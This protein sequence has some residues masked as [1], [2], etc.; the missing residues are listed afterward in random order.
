MTKVKSMVQK[1]NE[2]ISK[3]PRDQVNCF[4]HSHSRTTNSRVKRQFTSSTCSELAT[5]SSTEDDDGGSCVST[6]KTSSIIKDERYSKTSGAK[7]PPFTG[8]EEWKVWHSRFESVANL[9]RW[10][11]HEKLQQLLPRIQGKAAEFVYGQLKPAVRSQYKIFVQEMRERFD[12][13]ETTKAYVTQISRRNQNFRESAEEYAAELKRLYDRAYPK[14]GPET[15]QEDLLRRFLMGLH[16]NNARMHVEL[17]KEPN[18]IEEAVHHVVH[19]FEAARST[20]IGITRRKTGIGT[21]GQD[22]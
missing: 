6:G 8:T 9:N 7:L 21:R 4:T 10:G 1:L 3:K 11:V 16:N 12:G 20:N 14:R 13:F 5:C 2:K 17:N 18:T 15:R 19:Y 22:R